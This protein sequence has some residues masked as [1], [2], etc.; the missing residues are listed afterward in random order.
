MDAEI[1]LREREEKMQNEVELA[2]KR[3][4]EKELEEIRLAE[5]RQRLHEKRNASIIKPQIDRSVKPQSLMGGHYDRN[6]EPEWNLG[7]MVRFE[8]CFSFKFTN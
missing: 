6:F 3:I 8:F 4:K 2:A 1:S 5:E 7:T